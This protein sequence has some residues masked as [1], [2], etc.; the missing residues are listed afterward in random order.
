MKLTPS[1]KELVVHFQPGQI[2]KS[3]FLGYDKRSIDD[4]IKS[5]Q[6]VLD[7]FGL[8]NETVADRLKLFIDDGEKGLEGKVDLG[9]WIVQVHWARGLMPCPFGDL[10]L[11]SK[12]VVQVYS[13]PLNKEIRYTQ[14]S[15]HMIRKH[16]FWGGNGS[17]FRLE[18]E[19]VV[20]LLNVGVMRE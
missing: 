10:G 14:L 17:A 19:D 15:V 12:I 2:T 1:E 20:R 6:G 4:I 7:R 16:G 18:P 5:D 13:K 3:G 11:H 9:E 8:K